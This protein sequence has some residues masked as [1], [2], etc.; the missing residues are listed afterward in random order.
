LLITSDIEYD[1]TNKQGSSQGQLHV[2]QKLRPRPS[3]D[4]SK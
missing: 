3:S 2:R 1:H 4:I